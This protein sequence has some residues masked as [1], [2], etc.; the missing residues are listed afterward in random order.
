[1]GDLQVNKLEIFADV[2]TYDLFFST[3]WSEIIKD[4]DECSAIVIDEK[5]YSFVN[6]IRTPNGG[7]HEAG[8]RAGLTRA[9][10]NYNKQ[11]GNA[12]EKDT[13]ISGDD[14]Y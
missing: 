6:N 11:N 13:N 2:G 14:G 12:K 7:T 8:F 4:F 1:M 9:I 3:D 10:S 5:V